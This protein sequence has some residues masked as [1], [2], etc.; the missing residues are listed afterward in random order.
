MK[1]WRKWIE[2]GKGAPQ[3]KLD[4]WFNVAQNNLQWLVMLRV[5]RNELGAG[6]RDFKLS[7]LGTWTFQPWYLSPPTWCLNW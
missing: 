4:I 1:K 5:A 3:D 6:S 7:I 2:G